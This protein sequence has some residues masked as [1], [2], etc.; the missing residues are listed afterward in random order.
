MTLD[1]S[2]PKDNLYAFGKLWGY[3]GDE[4]VLGVYHG[5]IFGLIG[6]QRVRPLFGYAGTGICK[7]RILD[8]GDLQ[9]RGKETNFITDLQS[10]EVLSQ[11]HNPYTQEIVEPFHFV[12]DNIGAVMGQTMERITVG[13][14][15]EPGS[16]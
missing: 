12:H 9:M 7:M 8:N 15:E 5:T 2:C 3:Y 13:D 11:W 10:G 6:R 16:R 1:L 14:S 4:P